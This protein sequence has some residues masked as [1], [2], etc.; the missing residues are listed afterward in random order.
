MNLKNLSNEELVSHVELNV[1]SSPLE[2]VLAKRLSNII[3][4]NRRYA[5]AIETINEVKEDDI[6][7]N[8][9]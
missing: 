5:D 8:N 1:Y 7:S 4:I 2:K 6:N 9:E 3:E